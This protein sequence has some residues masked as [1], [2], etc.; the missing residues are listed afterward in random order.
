MP[1]GR[2]A[3]ILDGQELQGEIID[4]TVFIVRNDDAPNDGQ[5]LQEW[6]FN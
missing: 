3:V 5:E 1:H 2:R 4:R 6:D